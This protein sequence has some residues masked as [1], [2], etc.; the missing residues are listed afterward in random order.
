M[1]EGAVP[2]ESMRQYAWL[3]KTLKAAK[4]RPIAIFQH[5]PFFLHTADEPDGYWNV[6]LVARTK[7]LALLKQYGVHHVYAGH[8][9]YTLH[10]STDDLQITVAGPVGKPLGKGV[11]GMNLVQVNPD[12]IWQER[13]FSLSDMPTTLLLAPQ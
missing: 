1:A 13:Y 5:I 10:S 2:E 4:G 3:E 12:G 11:S 6:P 8:L 9:H 7:Y